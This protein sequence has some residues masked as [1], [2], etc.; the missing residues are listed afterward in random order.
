MSYERFARVYDE[1]MN[2]VDYPSWV[3][4]VKEACKT[5]APNS[6]TFLDVGCGTGTLSI[7]LKQAGFDVTGVDLSDDMLMIANA[8]VMEKNLSIPFYQQ[9]MRQLEGFT[10]FDAIG[11]FCDSL[12]YLQSEEDVKQTFQT[13]YEHLETDGLFIF[14]VHSIFKMEEIFKDQ[15][16]TLNEEEI[17]YI[18]NCYEGEHPYSVEHDL[19]FFVLDSTTNQYDRFDEFHTQ[20]TFPIDQYKNWLDEANF[21]VLDVLGD[22]EQEIAPDAHRLIFIC[23]KK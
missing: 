14:D 6:K 5:Y 23:Q 19:S 11:I 20:R 17:S 3:R 10:T 13:V 4:I 16:F 1:L 12:N 22:F 2:D 9:D 8:K 21:K 7:L 15:T 18:W